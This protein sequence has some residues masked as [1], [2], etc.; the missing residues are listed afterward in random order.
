LHS[1]R[2]IHA[3][4]VTVVLFCGVIAANEAQ[5]LSP[6]IMFNIQI[7]PSIQWSINYVTVVSLLIPT[8]L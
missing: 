6:Q 1:Y 2:R 8:R 7:G 4:G 3:H 5:K